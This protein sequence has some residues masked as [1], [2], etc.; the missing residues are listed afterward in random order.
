MSFLMGNKGKWSQHATVTPQVQNA[1]S[2]LLSHAMGGL[3]GNQGPQQAS[4]Q[5]LNSPIAQ[6]T[7]QNFQQTTIPGIAEMFSGMGSGG[8]Q[9]SSAFAHSLGQAGAGLE[10]NLASMGQQYGQ[11]EQQNLMQMLQ[12]AFMPQIENTY[13]QGQPGALHGL[14]GGIGQG[15]G[16]GAGMWATGGLSGLGKLLPFLNQLKGQA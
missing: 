4:N 14:L 15:L 16:Q 9:R 13:T 3:M 10:S 1:L 2:Q 12:M 5:F 11:Q 8:G 6:Q 7:R